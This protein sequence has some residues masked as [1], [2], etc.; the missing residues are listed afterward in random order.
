MSMS[1]QFSKFGYEKL[2]IAKPGS[3]PRTVYR[4]S[5]E[6]RAVHLGALA[7]LR[8]LRIDMPFAYGG[9][10]GRSLLDHVEQHAG[11]QQFYLLDLK[12]AFAS[13]D[14][15]YLRAQMLHAVG[16]RSPISISKMR[17]FLLHEATI[18]GVD[19]LPLGLPASPM[20]FNIYCREMDHHIGKLCRNE[21]I[22]YTR[23]L[24]DLTF[25]S[26]ESPSHFDRPLRRAIRA[27]I[28]ETP[29]MHVNDAKAK[30]LTGK[31]PVTIT[32][33]TVYPATA[34]GDVKIAPSRELLETVRATFEEAGAILAA[35]HDLTEDDVALLNGYNSVL[36]MA[37]DPVESKSRAVRD[38]SEVYR[39]LTRRAV[40]GSRR[41][42]FSES[43]ETLFDMST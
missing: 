42:T 1:E 21:G 20:L 38:F 17:D 12:D 3:K 27:I 18:D 2:R 25:S 40:L 22:T 28:H 11:H 15:S 34:T 19:G 26:S 32:G 8:H 33:L 23:W 6:L 14:I 13:V 9:V 16:P 10:R 35:G 39:A 24:D 30:L 41:L 31:K 5:D 37:G 7:D 29:G 36:H 43:E 4:P